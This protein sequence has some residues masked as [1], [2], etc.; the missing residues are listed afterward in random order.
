MMKTQS[1]PSRALWIL[2]LLLLASLAQGCAAKAPRP[3]EG[4]AGSAL[5]G[6]AYSDS[7]VDISYLLGHS[8]RR[9]TAWGK[10]DAFEGQAYMDH[11]ILREGSIARNHYVE[12][13]AKVEQFVNSPHRRPAEEQADPGCRS[14][15]IVT[16]RIGTVTRVIQGCRG[17]DDGAL[18]HLVRDGEFLLYSSR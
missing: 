1:S 9:L 13:L 17:T 10:K 5:S 3:E 18:S 4:T 12:F 15:F 14:P 7:S 6:E 16:L 11:Q 2:P 8:H